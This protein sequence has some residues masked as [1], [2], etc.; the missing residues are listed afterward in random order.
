MMQLGFAF[1]ET[2]Q[3]RNKNVTTSMLKNIM[4]YLMVAIGL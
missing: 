4:I 1:L 3:V 2:T